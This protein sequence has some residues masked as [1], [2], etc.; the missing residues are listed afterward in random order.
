MDKRLRN[1]KPCLSGYFYK[2]DFL[3]NT[4][5]GIRRM[6]KNVIRRERGRLVRNE[7]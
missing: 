7:A 5:F 3:V 6:T 4:S 2:A 1:L